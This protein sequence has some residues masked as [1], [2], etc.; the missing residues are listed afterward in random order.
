[1]VSIIIILHNLHSNKASSSRDDCFFY[2]YCCFVG[3]KLFHAL[4]ECIIS[5]FKRCVKLMKIYFLET[6]FSHHF[7]VTILRRQCCAIVPPS[8]SCGC[9]LFVSLFVCTLIQITT[10]EKHSLWFT[11]P[12]RTSI[13]ACSFAL[14]SLRFSCLA[15]H[16]RSH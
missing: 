10:R 4:S 6:L 2:G 13:H 5:P 1:M 3:Y 12:F 15:L 11:D 16:F 9:C 14:T 8:S 7:G